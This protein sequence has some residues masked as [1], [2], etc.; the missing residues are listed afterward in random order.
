MKIKVKNLGVLKQAEFT[1]GD[2]TIICGGN[3]SGKTYATYALFG[4]LDTWREYVAIDI[5]SASIEQ[6]LST[7][8][9]RIDLQQY[10]DNIDEIVADTC[11]RYTKDLSKIFASPEGRFDETEFQVYIEKSDIQRVDKIDVKITSTDGNTVIF[12]IEKNKEN[13]EI[14]I[15]AVSTQVVGQLP[16][17]TV[18]QSIENV[19][20]NIILSLTFSRTFIASVERTGAAIFRKDLNL[21]RNILFDRLI[22]AGRDIGTD[23]NNLNNIFRSR[24]QEYPL[25]VKKNVDFMRD[26]E[27]VFKRSSFIAKEHPDILANFADII[28]GEYT[29]TRE[30]ELYY[31]PKQ[32]KRVRLSMDG[33]SSAVRSLLDIG[34]YLKHEAQRGDLLMID[35][36]EL[37]LHPENQRRVA[38]LI[39]RLINI[40]IKVFITTHSDYI[41]KELN[42]LIM[43]KQD[44]PY[45]KQIA[46]DEGYLSEE[47]LSADRI[48]VYIAEEALVKLD[49][50]TRKVKCPTLT[51]AKIDSERGIE[52][53]SFDIT[54]DDMNRIQDAIIWGGE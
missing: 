9:I 25:P 2:L 42:T 18:K 52:A 38:R 51:A 11:H 5:P 45:L 4:F 31:I 3:N 29:V 37:N 34:F 41:I 35:E 46:E 10:I 27:N 1:L 39:A 6:L 13:M 36:P 50:K 15:T 43:L 19:I 33:S 40:G 8:V 44:L 28:G 23:V 12:S 26:L 21:S 14:A 47:L 53:R 20:E 24:S 48:K 16:I 22:E 49:G 30:D 32:G 54:I 17:E 7:G